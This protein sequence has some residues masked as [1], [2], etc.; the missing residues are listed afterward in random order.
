MAQQNTIKSPQ[1][2][3]ISKGAF[4]RFSSF[5]F[6]TSPNMAKY[7]YGCSTLEPQKIEI[8]SQTCF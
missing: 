3:A 7:T 2:L 8:K 5:I 1:L 6:G 4:L